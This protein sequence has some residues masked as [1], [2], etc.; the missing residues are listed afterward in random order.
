M[1]QGEQYRAAAAA[2]GA[3]A[4]ELADAVTAHPVT[5]PAHFYALHAYVARVSAQAHSRSAPSERMSRPSV[6]NT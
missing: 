4:P 6:G 3:A 1:S 2:G 5:E